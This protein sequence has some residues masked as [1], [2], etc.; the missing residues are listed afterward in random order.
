MCEL[1]GFSSAHPQ[2]MLPIL[3][4]FF[5][6]SVN[7]PDGWGLAVMQGKLICIEKEPKPAFQSDYLKERLSAPLS[8]KTVLGHIRKASVGC[9][10][11]RN[12]H[13][14]ALTDN[15]DRCW[16][17]VHNG[18]IFHSQSLS[19]YEPVQDGSTDSERIL[20]CLVDGINQMQTRLHRMLRFPEVFRFMEETFA[21]LSEGNQ[22]NVMLSDGERLYVHVNVPEKLFVCQGDGQAIFA[23]VPLW[24]NGWEPVPLCTLLA[25]QNGVL[26]RTGHCHGTIYHAPAPEQ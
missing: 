6:R 15:R 4:P 10:Q 19:R 11:Y 21:A 13:P 24:E 17:L 20:C 5:A 18:T 7:H 25:Y 1:L 22:L 9:I 26:L 3:K 23:T 2:D 14:F 12:C 8:A 16:V